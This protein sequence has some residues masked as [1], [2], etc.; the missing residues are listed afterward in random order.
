MSTAAPHPVPA[1]LDE[2]L[3][4]AMAK[5]PAKRFPHLAAFASAVL[6]EAPDWARN[7]SL[8][9]ARTDTHDVQPAQAQTPAQNHPAP[10]SCVPSETPMAQSAQ[11]PQRRG[12]TWIVILGMIGSAAIAAV[13]AV[14]VARS[15]DKSGEK[16]PKAGAAKSGSPSSAPSPAP[17][18]DETSKDPMS[19]PSSNRMYRPVVPDHRTLRWRLP[20]QYTRYPIYHRYCY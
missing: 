9:Y 15:T 16:G 18:A 10:V 1:H 2:V 20:S 4:T 12:L 13:I 7:A 5:D 19:S 17:S 3:A 8:G 6:Q 11:P 14:L